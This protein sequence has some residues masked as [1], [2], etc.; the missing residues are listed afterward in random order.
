M[1]IKATDNWQAL[2][3]L[4]R[5]NQKRLLF[6]F[7]LVAA[8]N[9]LYLTYPLFSAFAI[10]AM[11]RGEIFKALLYSVFVLAAWSLGALR[12]S[13]DTRVF[14]RMYADLTVPVIMRQRA[15]GADTSAIS[16]RVMLSHELVDFFEIHLPTLIMSGFSLIGA[17]IMLL[18]LEFWAGAAA[19]AVLLVFGLM[20]PR[21]AQTNDSLYARLN[22]RL[23]KEVCL[24]ENA[25]REQLQ[26]HYRYTARLRIRLS[27]R[28]ALGFLWIGVAMAVV[29]GT[30]VIQLGSR[31][32]SA[33]HIYAVMT[34]L[35]TF[36]V[37][38][39]DGPRLLEEFSKLKDIEKRVDTE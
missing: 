32:V 15:Q 1:A 34:Y 17:G 18:F 28:E 38:L 6:T 24:I 29:F 9:I 10:D 2:K 31:T 22:N 5:H 30:A 20:L 7:G 8:E 14:A 27:N 26:R 4:A 25:G 36:A 21:Y 39:D 3:Y 19:A 33:G 11:V 13:V 37:A 23:E 12:R 16:A 35:W